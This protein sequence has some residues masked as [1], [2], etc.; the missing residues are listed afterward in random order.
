MAERRRHSSLEISGSGTSIAEPITVAG[1]GF[2]SAP[3]GAIRMVSA[4]AGAENA[5]LILSV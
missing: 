3:T 1:L 5:S 2:N 4:A